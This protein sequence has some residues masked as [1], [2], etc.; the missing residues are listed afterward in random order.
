[1]TR[2][3]LVLHC[4]LSFPIASLM[5]KLSM[6]RQG[7]VLGDVLLFFLKKI[8]SFLIFYMS[9]I[10][11]H[12]QKEKYECLKMWQYDKWCSTIQHLLLLYVPS[13]QIRKLCPWPSQTLLYALY[14]NTY[15]FYAKLCIFFELTIIFQH[16][17]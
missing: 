14:S 5:I 11:N 13:Q 15:V 6:T 16:F 1:M 2:Y 12:W 3:L 17:I 8:Y 7:R 4:H 10:W 9:C